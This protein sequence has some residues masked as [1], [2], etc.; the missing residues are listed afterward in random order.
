MYAKLKRNLYDIVFEAD[1]RAGK[2]FD[3]SLLIAVLLSVVGVMLESIESFNTKYYDFL[4]ITEWFFTIIFTFE[5]ILRILIVIKKSK[6]IF[7]FYGIIDLLAI[8]PTYIGLLIPGSTHSLAIIR[9]L[10]LFRV[11]RIFKLSRYV[12]E[13]HTLIRALISSKQKIGVFFFFVIMIVIILGTVMYLVEDKSGGFT[14][15]PQGIY[16]AIVTLTTVGYGDIAPVTDLGKFIAGA[17]MILGY[18][19]IAIPTGIITSEIYKSNNENI[20]TQVCPNCLKEG[21]DLNAVYCKF[22]GAEINPEIL[23]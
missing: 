9:S 8:L 17:V 12:S 3:I 20:T 1:T 5:Y 14:S 15:I 19:I 4:H 10:R 2:M 21:H 6:Y 23:E 13:S 11:F 7:S 18:A 16:W 22:C